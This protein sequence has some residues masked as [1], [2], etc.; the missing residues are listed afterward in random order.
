MD[1]PSLSL[2]SPV[3]DR[4]AC[5]AAGFREGD[6]GTHTSR[7]MMLAELVATLAAVRADATRQ[8]Y[9]R[10]IV[11]DNCLGKA[12]AAT[13]ALTAQRLAE[14]YALDPAVPLFRILRRLWNV[15]EASH[16]LL[17]VLIALARDPLLAATV[18]SVI[19]LAP[20][21]EFLRGPMREAIRSAVGQRLNDAT[22]D[23]VARNAASSWSQAGH[24]A[25]RTF[26]VRQ[27]VRPTPVSVAMGMYLG[28]VCG[29]RG[30][31]V[32]ASEWLAI[33]DCSPSEAS[34]LAFEAKRLGLIDLRYAGD[35]LDIDF[36]RLD[37][38]KGGR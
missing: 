5:L 22:I 3:V 7:T 37:P 4:G 10:C 16:P 26:K 28:F 6:R 20:N 29:L 11:D 19:P 27:R 15:D 14:L 38:W 24:L 17:A 18:P 13:R 30:E 8:A 25:G 2:F 32:M 36:D 21:T 9:V 23:K 31:S 12:T 34:S 35:V 33:I 1:Q